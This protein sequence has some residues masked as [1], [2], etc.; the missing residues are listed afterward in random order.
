MSSNSEISERYTRPST[1]QCP[2]EIL[3]P[4]QRVDSEQQAYPFECNEA[5][6]GMCSQLQNRSDFYIDKGGREAIWKCELTRPQH[7]PNPLKKASEPSFTKIFLTQSTTPLSFRSLSVMSR[8]L[9]T[10]GNGTVRWR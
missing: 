3:M 1:I 8:T 7:M 9:T 5:N 4:L 2:M 10:S 6:Y